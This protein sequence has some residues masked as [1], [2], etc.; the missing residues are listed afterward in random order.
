[1]GYPI[2]LGQAAQPL[3][4]L[5]IDSTD[6][7]SG[8]AG[9]TPTVTIS[10]NGATFATPAGAVAEIGDGW[11]KVAGNAA[12]ANTLGPL[13]LHA[14]ASGA[15][16]VDELYPVVAFNPLDGAALG[17]ANLDVAT[18]TRSTLVGPAGF[19]TLTIANN[20][21]NLNLAQAGL[22]P[23]ALDS[24]ADGSLTVG[25]GLVA[26]IAGA[27]GKESVAGTS[28]LVKTPSTGTVI[29]TF[30]LDSASNP[31]SRS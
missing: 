6:H 24:V 1:M 11:Y 22:T 28:Y 13:I 7:L 23:R 21:I 15:D 27:A 18:S 20:G 16:P 26:A 30:V 2:M 14:T 29:R 10:K 8:K 4:F 17:L 9:L 12:D 5:M 25:D 19:S 31:T 3:G